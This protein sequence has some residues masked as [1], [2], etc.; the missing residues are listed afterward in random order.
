MVSVSGLRGVVGASLTPEVVS[1]YAAA[2]ASFLREQKG[3]A[4]CRVVVGRDGRRGGEAV[5]SMAIGALMAS[6]CDV[7]DCGVVMTPTVGV[8]VERLGATGGLVVTASHNPGAWNGMKPIT[9]LG[10]APNPQEASRIVGAF[11]E[12]RGGWAAS[13]GV[14]R[15]E[16]DSSANEAHIDRV[17]AALAGIVDLELIRQRKV[18]VVLDSVNASGV[19]GGRFLLERLGCQVVHLNNDETGVFPHEPE[20]TAANLG[21][22]CRAVEA[23]D[24]EI[25]FAQDPDGDRLAIVDNTGA[26]IGEEYTLALAAASLLS[27]MPPERASR[28]TLAANLSTSRMV[29][30]VAARFGARVVRTPVGEAN[31]VAGMREA[32]C[33][34]GGEGNGGVIWGEVCP[35][36]DSLGSMALVLALMA[37]SGGTIQHEMDA[38]PAYAIEKRK[39]DAIDLGPIDAPVAESLCDAFPGARVTSV[40]GV[41]L[42][43]EVDGG[44]AWVHVRASNTEPIVRLIAE[45]PSRDAAARV[46]D[47]AES[48]VRGGG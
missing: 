21:E 30:D 4:R 23:S 24:A 13:E 34:L 11:R 35:I 8:M 16:K 5:A 1:R 48:V 27:A 14:G 32:G 31:V 9:A 37:R 10:G 25:G 47:T 29:E 38:I 28:Q 18:K 36:R 7:T 43:F 33:E 41:R 15:L 6:G 42:D 20:P 3:D 45:A 17:L 22:L 12:G 39:I 40:D 2:V 44:N 26:Y 46:L 19:I